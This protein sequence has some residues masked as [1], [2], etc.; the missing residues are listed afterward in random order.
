MLKQALCNFEEEIWIRGQNIFIDLFLNAWMD[1]LFLFSWLSKLTLKH[2]L[3]F[4]WE[5]PVYLTYLSL[6]HHLIISSPKLQNASLKKPLLSAANTLIFSHLSLT[7]ARHCWLLQ[8]LLGT[9]SFC[10]WS[11]LAGGHLTNQHTNPPW[12]GVTA[13][14]DGVFAGR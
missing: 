6:Y 4:L 5:Q 3:I 9:S 1:K 12:R 10:R 11:V 2:N 7:S 13:A 8:G 14:F